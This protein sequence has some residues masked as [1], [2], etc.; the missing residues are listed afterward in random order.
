MVKTFQECIAT[1]NPITVWHRPIICANR[2]Y[3]LHQITNKQ[4]N[5]QTCYWTSKLIHSSK[6]LQILSYLA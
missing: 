2:T 5:K 1:V 6:Y 4:T 3:T